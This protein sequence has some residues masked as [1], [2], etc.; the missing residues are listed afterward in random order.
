[1]TDYKHYT[2]LA[3]LFEYPTAEIICKS[4]ECQAGLKSE[5]R[6]AAGKLQGFV[7]F[8]NSTALYRIEEIFTGTFHIQAIC[9]LDLG[10]VLFGED[11][12]RGEFLVNMKNEQIKAGNDCGIEL[13]DNLVNVL[14]LLPRIKEQEFLEELAVRIIMPAL[15]KM[16][17]E[18]DASRIALKMKV[19]RKK[20]QA[21]I[22]SNFKNGNIYRYA[23]EALLL[24][25]E[26][27]FRDLIKEEPEIPSFNVNP[28]LNNCGSCSV[29]KQ[30]LNL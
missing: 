5:Y 30:P 8:L 12:K 26:K 11:Y 19:L 14:T 22:M 15:R 24:V 9:Y 29:F 4:S 6:D 27:D 23:L 20:H 10:Y 1:M 28:F 17:A 3:K 13:A 7:D 21:I 25:L 18:F 16:L 2:L